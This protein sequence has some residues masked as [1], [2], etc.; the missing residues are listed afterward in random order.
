MGK[1][2]LFLLLSAFFFMAACGGTGTE[3][4]TW[5]MTELC[6]ESASDYSTGG[7]D[8]LRMDVRFVHGQDTLVR[9]A[10]WDGE[11]VFRVR[12]APTKAGKWTWTTTCPED[13]S[14]DS[15]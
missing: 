8:R 11:N 5:R 2:E 15:H 3:A 7:G 12:F 9:P 13:A 4:E 10:F 6:F 1:T 14:L